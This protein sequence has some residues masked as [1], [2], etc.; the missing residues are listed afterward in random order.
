[1][2]CE[3]FRAR[4]R[5]GRAAARHGLCGVANESL[6]LPHGRR[7]VVELPS[8]LEELLLANLM[9]WIQSFPVAAFV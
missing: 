8:G 6:L 4:I 9:T 2:N 3:P 5:V 1:M 7:L